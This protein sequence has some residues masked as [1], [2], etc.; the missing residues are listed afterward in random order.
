MKK[1]PSKRKQARQK[2]RAERKS[3]RKTGTII[4]KDKMTNWDKLVARVTTRKKKKLK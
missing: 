3:S 1:T 4:S 2:L